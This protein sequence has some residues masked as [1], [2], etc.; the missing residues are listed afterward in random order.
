[1]TTVYSGLNAGV[2]F[3]TEIGSYHAVL[4]RLMLHENAYL[5]TNHLPLESQ[6][7]LNLWA[8]PIG[9]DGI[10]II[11]HPDNPVRALSSQQL[12]E[13]YQGYIANWRDLGGED[14]EI[15]VISREDGSGTR[16]EF[17][18]QVMGV[19]RT[20]QAAQIAP[21]SAAVIEIVARQPGC[22]GYVSMS[23]L[24]TSVNALALD[25][26]MLTRQ[27]V[28]QHTYPLRSTL[29]VVGQREPQNHERAFIGWLQS[30][31]GQSLVSQYAAPL[32]VI[33]G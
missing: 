27:S 33:P 9:Q 18:E 7:T 2:R 17:E 24:R 15:I 10:A 16:A 14:R 26:V 8:A 25:G 32:I 22:I 23:Y 28:E 11:V 12:R 13:I 30:P 1:M 19:R 21:S 3:E 5:L 20:T 6:A 31:A 29:F 4:D